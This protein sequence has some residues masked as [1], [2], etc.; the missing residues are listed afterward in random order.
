VL[1]SL[2]SGTENVGVISALAYPTKKLG[3]GV[4]GFVGVAGGCVVA[5]V[6][7]AVVASVD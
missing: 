7:E 1:I 5:V 4:D 2:S 3:A 6:G